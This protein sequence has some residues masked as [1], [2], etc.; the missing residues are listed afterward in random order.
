MQW[1]MTELQYARDLHYILGHE[2]CAVRLLPYLDVCSTDPLWE[3]GLSL[4][5]MMA[6]F[7]S[8]LPHAAL[9]KILISRFLRPLKPLHLVVAA[10]TDESNNGEDAGDLEGAFRNSQS[11]LR[12]RRDR[13]CFSSDNAGPASQCEE[14]G[15]VVRPQE[16]LEVK[17]SKEFL[18]A[19]LDALSAADLAARLS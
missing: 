5:S 19:H 17:N 16:S 12:R 3:A 6:P 7:L 15:I 1:H 13:H 2:A 18:I 8:V 14:K 9:R 11:D 10:V 4:R